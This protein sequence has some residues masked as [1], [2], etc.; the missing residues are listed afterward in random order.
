MLMSTDYSMDQEPDMGKAKGQHG[1]FIVTSKRKY[2][3]KGRRGG[4]VVV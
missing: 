1:K 4:Q 3:A 2:V